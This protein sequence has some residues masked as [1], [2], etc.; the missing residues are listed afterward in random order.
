MVAVAQITRATRVQPGAA[1]LS[2][3]IVEQVLLTALEGARQPMV[4]ALQ[5]QPLHQL[6]HPRQQLHQH[7][8]LQQLQPLHL[9]LLSL[10][11]QMEAVA[12]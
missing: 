1:V 10:R 3:A 5:A 12:L 2:L 11:A 9:L 7:Q 4:H 6:H 8:Q